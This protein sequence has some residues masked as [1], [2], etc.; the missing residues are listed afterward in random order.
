LLS[1]S[2]LATP[3]DFRNNSVQKYEKKMTPERI[4]KPEKG[5]DKDLKPE[6]HK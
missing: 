4:F 5:K 1:I 6:M 2:V 3:K